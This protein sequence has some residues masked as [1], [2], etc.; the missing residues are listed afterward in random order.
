MC[1][2]CGIALS[3]RSGR[4]LEPRTLERMRNTLRHRGPDDA[5]LF[6]DGNIGLGHQR[7]SIVDVAGG[8]QPMLSEDENLCIVYNGEVYNHPVLRGELQ[9]RGCR[10]RTRCDTETVLHLYAAHGSASPR[11]LRGMFAFA[12]WDRARRELF[13][14]RDRF[15]VK[16]LYYVLTVD[17]SLYFASEIKALLAAAAVAPR[18]NVTALPDYLANHA[19]SGTETLFEG[20]HRLAAGTTLRWRDGAVQI[21]PYWDLRRGFDSAARDERAER[22]LVAE[23]GCRFREAVRLRL[24]A[25][26]PL[27][28]FLSAESTPRQ[29]RQR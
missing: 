29:S 20:V 13:L 12:I 6:V 8:H 25:D 3:S 17:G 11:H 23:F 21:E 24:M 10:Y 1:G 22:D 18:L 14:A 16:P 4:R 5:G 7:L 2:I 28:V 15:G 19:P 26:V 9:A 27:G